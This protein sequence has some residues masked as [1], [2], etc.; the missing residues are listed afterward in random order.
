MIGLLPMITT[1]LAGSAAAIALPGDRGRRVA[2]ALAG[3]GAL[4]GLATALSVIGSG[5]AAVFDLPS[6]VPAL[7]LAFRLDA[8][9]AFFLALIGLVAVPAAI[10]ADAYTKEEAPPSGTP[11]KAA[12]RSGRLA[13]A[14]LNLFLLAMSLVVSAANVLA[15]LFAWEAMSLASYLLVVG[16]GEKAESVS[17]GRWYAG[18]AHAGFGLIAAAFFLLAARAGG[19]GFETIRSLSSSPGPALRNVVFLLA[20]LGFGSKAGIVPLHVWLPR[21]HPAAPSHV[22]ALM[23]GAMLPIGVYGLLRVGLDLLGGGPPWW[24]GVVLALGAVSALKG[25]LYALTEQDLKRLL[26]YSSIENLGIVF[27]GIGIGFVFHGHG[28]ADLAAVALAAGLYHALNH[29]AFKGLLFLGSGAV[30]KATGTRNLEEMGGLIKRMPQTAACFLVGAAAIAALPP[31][32]GFASEWLLLQVFMAGASLPEGLTAALMAL[33]VGTLA[34]AGGLAAACFVKAFGIPFLALPRSRAAEEAREVAGS[35]RFAMIALAAACA[36]LGLA[37]S[38]VMSFLARVLGGMP[39]VDAGGALFRPG[40]VL[41]APQGSSRIAPPLLALCL[42]VVIA[43]LVVGLRLLGVRGR[44]RLVETWGCGRTVQTSRMEITSMAFAEPL[45]RV[46]AGLYRPTK[47]LT[48][49]FH[50]ESKYFVRSI[51]YRSRIRSWFEEDL[52]RSF[53]DLL[54]PLAASGRLIQSGSVHLYLAYIV[55][56]LLIFLL[57]GRWL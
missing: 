14:T 21:A 2:Q 42:I 28:R 31:L 56:A 15:F 7:G 5:K 6:S 50:P 16:D 12:P 53:Y 46:F 30:L 9:G 55:A 3:A 48:I 33:A 22:S 41:E 51:T 13:G 8:L 29:A 38:V 35:M 44:T 23:S 52:Y 40:S 1:Y 4:L 37:P 24:G 34:L 49:G 17:A 20:L 36:L 32:N 54:R 18:M 25:V 45:R 47:D 43:A 26:A 10:Y 39:G 19:D 11:G 57:L 27:M